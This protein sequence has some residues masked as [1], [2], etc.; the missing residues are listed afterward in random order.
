MLIWFVMLYLLI[1]IG[2]G[3]Y[4]ATRVHSAKDYAVAGRSLP[5]Y[6]VTATVFATWFGSET[7]LGTSATFLQ[8]GLKGI[9][10]DP[11]GASMCLVLV[12]LF[13][14]RRLY[15]MNLLTIGDYYRQRYGRTVEL[16]TSLAIVASYLGWVSAQITA[17]G[18]VFSLL[19]HGSISAHDGMIIGAGIVLVYTLFGGMWSVAFTVFFQMIIIVVGMLYIGWVVSGYAGGVGNVVGHAQAA[20][21]FQFWPR[22]ETRDILAFS[23]AWVTMMFGSIPQQDV[24]QRVMSAR[25][26][27]IAV[28]GAVLGGSLYFLFAFIPIFLAYSALLI[29]PASVSALLGT[30]PQ[31]IL[32]DL[33]LNHTPVFAQVMF[34]GAL[35]SA[36]MSTASGTLLA[37]SV[38]FTENILK[39][40]IGHLSDRH[41]LWAMRA[42]VVG[43]ACIVTVFALN[44]GASIYKMVENAYKVTL[45][46]AFVPLVFGL[47]WKRANTRGALFAIVAGVSSWLLLEIFHPDGLWPPQLFGLL[48]SLAGMLV[49]SLISRKHSA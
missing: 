39:P 10:A 15:R 40:F 46:A 47:Y 36:I 34:F 30:D 11:F 35:L 29:D 8:G 26:E 2:I 38:T 31:H 6:I 33:I 28:T 19:T 42:V 21:K 22:L 24:F 43:F 9:V 7:V 3:L 32:P 16:L 5:L 14:A 4:A 49:G 12:G 44:S 17:L 13:F 20:G 41:L 1:S 23:A 25:S 18:L 45:V 48:M 37:P 27:N